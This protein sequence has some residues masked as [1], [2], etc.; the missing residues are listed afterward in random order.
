MY[1]NLSNQDL[2]SKTTQEL[3]EAFSGIPAGGF[4]RK[5]FR[6]R[7]TDLFWTILCCKLVELFKNSQVV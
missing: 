7:R 3:K 5:I 6:K 2:G 4:C 1:H